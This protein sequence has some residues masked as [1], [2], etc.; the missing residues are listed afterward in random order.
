M[1]SLKTYILSISA[2]RTIMLLILAAL[3]LVAFALERGDDLSA[4]FGDKAGTKDLKQHKELIIN[5]ENP[6][7][8]SGIRKANGKEENPLSKKILL[9]KKPEQAADELHNAFKA[10]ADMHGISIISEKPLPTSVENGLVRVPMEFRFKAALEQ[11]NGLVQDIQ[12]SPIIVGVRNLRISAA[13]ED[14]GL[15]DIE[16]VVEAVIED[17]KG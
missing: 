9:A 17:A 5:M 14:P 16:M 3:L 2:R 12:S 11:V 6:S 13:A 8:Q 10:M 4:L 7:A 15:L 1:P